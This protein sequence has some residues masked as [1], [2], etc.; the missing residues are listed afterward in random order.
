MSINNEEIK[1]NI[2]LQARILF[3][4]QGYE[5]TTIRQLVSSCHITNGTLYKYFA[6]KQEIFKAVRFDDINRVTQLIQRVIK[7]NND[8][9]LMVSLETHI[10]FTMVQKYERYAE[11]I[12]SSFD[13]LDVNETN[14]GDLTSFNKSCFAEY[15][16][17]YTD[18]DHRTR[19]L[20]VKGIY[21]S[22]IS[23]YLKGYDSDINSKISLVVKTIYKLH[24]VPEKEIEAILIKT[25]EIVSQYETDLLKLLD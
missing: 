20:I 17:S 10:V 9:L 24:D 4:T 15:I 22:I 5:Q 8:P 6:N 2:I 12:I 19:A 18:D 7:D 25:S 21:N 16:E 14:I 3:K 1:E 23:D 13:N 11:A